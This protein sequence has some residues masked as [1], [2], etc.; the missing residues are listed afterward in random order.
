MKE[1]WSFSFKIPKWWLFRKI[2]VVIFMLPACFLIPPFV[3]VQKWRWNK[4]PDSFQKRN[5]LKDLYIE[6]GLRSNLKS[7][8]KYFKE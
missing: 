6:N 4:K 8:W 7:W 3:F 2:L 1:Y 5:M